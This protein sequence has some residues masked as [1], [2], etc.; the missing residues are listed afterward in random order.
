MTWWD[1]LLLVGGGTIAGVINTMA[2]GGSTLTVPL[3]VLAGV[4]GNIA[5]GSN[6]VGVLASNV[7]SATSFRRLGVDGLAHATPVLI[8][9]VAGSLTRRAD[10]PRT[11]GPPPCRL[12]R[13]LARAVLGELFR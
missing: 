9:G 2:G 11:D 12:T 3:L 1:A 7:A 6:R 10:R 8:P 13:R 4:P 5:N